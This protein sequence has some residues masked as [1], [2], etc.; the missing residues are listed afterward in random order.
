ML[1]VVSLV[2]VLLLVAWLLLWTLFPPHAENLVLEPVEHHVDGR[3]LFVL[4]VI[5]LTIGLWLTN[6]WH[7]LPTAVVARVPAIAFTATGLLDQNDVN[8]LGWN[9]LILIAGGY[10]VGSRHAAH[11]TRSGARTAASG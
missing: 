3:G 6:R 2:V 5:A 4:G 1:V 10:C 7:G 11:Q 9:I 8:S